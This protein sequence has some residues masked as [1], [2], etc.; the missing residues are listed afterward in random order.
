LLWLL[1]SAFFDVVGKN[2]DLVWDASPVG[3]TLACPNDVAKPFNE[4]MTLA[5]LSLPL[6][7]AKSVAL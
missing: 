1:K 6:F 4:L 3:E 5:T 7:T 2:F